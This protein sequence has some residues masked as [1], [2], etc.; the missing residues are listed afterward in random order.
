[1]PSAPAEPEPNHDGNEAE[2]EVTLAANPFE[3]PPYAALIAAYHTSARAELINRIERRD[4]ALLVYLGAVATIFGVV[5]ADFANR[6]AALIVVPFLSLGASYIYAQHNAV[7]GAL[8]VFLGKE[9]HGSAQAI[10][11][12]SHVLRSW[13]ASLTLRDLRSHLAS[14]FLAGALILVGPA[15][16]AGVLAGFERG[17]TWE[18][19][20]IWLATALMVVLAAVTL[21]QSSRTRRR[22][23]AQIWAD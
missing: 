18:S 13:D 22:F 10:T 21:V 3:L 17:S 8:G 2:P 19:L 11:G 4:A 15:L 23:S 5:L 14:R 12:P 6:S 1:M 9:L 16:A 7:I 20:A